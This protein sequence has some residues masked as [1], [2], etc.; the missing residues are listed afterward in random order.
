[1][2]EWLKG[3]VTPRDIVAVTGIVCAAGILC[4]LFYFFVYSAQQTA[5]AETRTQLE[6]VSEQLKKAQETAKN[7]KALQEEAEKMELLVTLFEQR[8]PNEREIPALLQKF[9][10]LGDELGLKVELEDLPDTSDNQ[11]ETIPYLVTTRG[12]FH[13]IV[14]FIN[15]LEQE[16]RY[17]KISDL[18]IGPEEEGISTAT[19]TLS[20]FRFIETSTQSAP[21]E[22]AG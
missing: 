9:E 3:S 13:Q 6:T 7:F 12:T 8:L 11:K 4:A 5:L 18:D 17:L 14:S 21:S 16:D 20:T 10:G 1:M 22:P 2:I 19:F 15:L